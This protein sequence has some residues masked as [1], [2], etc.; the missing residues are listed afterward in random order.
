MKEE[1]VKNNSTVFVCGHCRHHHYGSAAIEF[2]FYDKKIFYLC[3]QCKKMNAIQFGKDMPPPY[4]KIG[5]G[6]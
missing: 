4:P 1:E 2:N 3:P 6:R 5:I